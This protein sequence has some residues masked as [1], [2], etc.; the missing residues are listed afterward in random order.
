[1]KP[2]P[3]LG[4]PNDP[5]SI[6]G[7]P[8]PPH[9]CYHSEPPEAVHLDHQASY[10]L[11]ER[12]VRCTVFL[13]SEPGRLPQ[14]IRAPETSPKGAQT[15]GSGLTLV[16]G[17]IAAAVL[18]ALGWALLRPQPPAAP[19]ATPLPPPATRVPT[20]TS[21]PLY[22]RLFEKPTETPSA[23]PSVTPTPTLHRP[24]F[25]S[26]TPTQSPTLTPSVTPSPFVSKHSLNVPIGTERQFVIRR[27]AFKENFEKYI[28]QYSTSF[29]AVSAINYD[30][31]LNSTVA[32][33]DMLVVFPVGFADVSGMHVLT[34]YQIPERERGV[35]YEYLAKKF[36]VE[37]A[38]FKYYNGITQ[39]GERPLVGEYYLIPRQVIP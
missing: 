21:T 20:L 39:A 25:G 38:L 13:L 33:A 31:R 29:K 8:F 17:F 36:K 19:T 12:H 22:L 11:T 32:R 2:C 16:G 9:R 28:Q 34:V 27:V 14:E 10:C 37:V 3:F 30:L 7:Y 26:A 24:L 6:A 5:D 18:L 23:I 35:S 1:M 4:L 15:G